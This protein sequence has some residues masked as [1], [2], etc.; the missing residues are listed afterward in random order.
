MCLICW[1]NL[2]N[3]S[4]AILKTSLNTFC[5]Q[6]F[7]SHFYLQL[8]KTVLHKILRGLSHNSGVLLVNKCRTH[9]FLTY[10]C[11][12]WL[13]L[14]LFV[15]PL[16]GIS[17]LSFFLQFLFCVSLLFSLVLVTGSTGHQ[18]EGFSRIELLFVLLC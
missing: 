10:S 15:S 17:S 18:C 12:S 8:F 3:T 9:T 5:W 4:L 6:P 2:Y 13:A 16:L 1:N 7:F 14:L 11:W